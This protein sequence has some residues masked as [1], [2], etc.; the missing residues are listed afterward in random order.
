MLFGKRAVV[1]KEWT[2]AYLMPHTNF[3]EPIEHGPIVLVPFHDKRLVE[4]IQASKA[5]RRL[6]GNFTDQ[7]GVSLAP[8]AVLIRST[9]LDKV[10]FY[11]VASFR[12]AV[13]VCSIIDAYSFQLSG[14]R[15]GYPLWADYFDFYPFTE[16]KD[17]E[18]MARSVASTEINQPDNFSGQRA[19]HLASNN[20]LSF[21]LDRAMLDGCLR[22]WDRRFIQ[23]QQEW[24]SRVLFRSLEMACQASRVPAVGTRTPTIHDMGVGIA[25]W[26][27]AFEILT[28]PPPKQ[29]GK[30]NLGTV[31]GLLAKPDW[32]DAKLRS[33]R[34]RIEYPKNTVRRVNVIQKLYCELYRARNDFL[35]GNPV[36]PR[37][38][39]PQGKAG[40]P[41]LLHCGPLIYRAALAAFVPNR[42]AEGNKTN[43]ASQISARYETHTFQ[44]R[45]EKAVIRCIR[46]RISP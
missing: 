34:Y 38:L 43:L 35:H 32:S 5:L 3:T 40:G 19:P 22:L 7:F 46:G 9:A 42:F 44:S 45:Y 37:K 2:F 23:C 26:V 39:F 20:R 14:G 15:A 10:D 31:L 12:N 1:N 28:H 11:A 4:L 36:T 30:A 13:A 29:K 8:S 18:L 25:L 33:K 24:Y 17:G 21:G 41:T 27:S 16:T 6:T